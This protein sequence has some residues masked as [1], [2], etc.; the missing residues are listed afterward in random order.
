L[1]AVPAATD[2]TAGIVL[3]A[4]S[5]DYPALNTSG[6]DTQATTAAYVKAAISAGFNS[7]FVFAPVT[8]IDYPTQAASR[9][10]VAGSLV[11][12]SHGVPATA[13]HIWARF[14]VAQI[15]DG[16]QTAAQST[17]LRFADGAISIVDITHSGVSTDDHRADGYAHILLPNRTFNFTV[18][19]VGTGTAGIVASNARV[20]IIGYYEA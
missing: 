15:T 9:A 5:T 3:L 12:A 16:T 10:N 8:A 7:P 17:H 6:D 18:E 14:R 20:S 4:D 1:A 13:T 11:P 19:T 2:T